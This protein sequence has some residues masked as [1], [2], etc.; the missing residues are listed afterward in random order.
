M[1]RPRKPILATGAPVAPKGLERVVELLPAGKVPGGFAREFC[2]IFR[3]E[4]EARFL[5][6][7]PAA[8]SESSS[9]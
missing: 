6:P 1:D 4:I 3:P 7:K 5:T 9:T 8:G 2:Q